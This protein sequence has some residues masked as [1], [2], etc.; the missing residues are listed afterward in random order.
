[1]N[2]ND[3][4]KKT[5]V[6][7]FERIKK[8]NNN[9]RQRQCVE[10]K[11]RKLRLKEKRRQNERERSTRMPVRQQQ[12]QQIMKENTN[13]TDGERMKKKSKQLQA[14]KKRESCKNQIKLQQRSDKRKENETP[15]IENETGAHSLCVVY[16]VHCNVMLNCN[17]KPLHFRRVNSF[18]HPHPSHL[19][20]QS[21]ANMC[22]SGVK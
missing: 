15:T 20:R 10:K 2:D 1:M 11:R 8:G 12:Q 17:G 14:R 21:A 7:A 22:E 13:E 18:T 3:A 16:S 6:K 5:K 9:N 4:R 19:T